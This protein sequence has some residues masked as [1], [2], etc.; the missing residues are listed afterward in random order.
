[1]VDRR[2][3]RLRSRTG[4]AVDARQ[5]KVEKPDDDELPR[6]YAALASPIPVAFGAGPLPRTAVHFRRNHFFG[7]SLTAWPVVVVAA[8]P[9]IGTFGSWRNYSLRGRR[10]IGAASEDCR[11]LP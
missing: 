11:Q 10:L 6:H 3:R 5:E 8:A 1:M 7:E 9:G 2:R 4:S